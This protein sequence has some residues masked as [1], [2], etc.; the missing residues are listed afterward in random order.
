MPL[1]NCKASPQ[2]AVS[3]LSRARPMQTHARGIHD[4]GYGRIAWFR[5]P[6]AHTF[7]L[8]QV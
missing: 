5:E 8:E 7:A 1:S 2:I 4:S 6:D 3:D